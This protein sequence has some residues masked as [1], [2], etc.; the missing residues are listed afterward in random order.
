MT[1][2]KSKDINAFDDQKVKNIGIKLVIALYIVSIVIVADQRAANYRYLE[3]LYWY[4]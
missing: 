2:L 1:N 3:F 4:Q